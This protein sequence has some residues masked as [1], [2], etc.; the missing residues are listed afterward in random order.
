MEID[1]YECHCLSLY[2]LPNWGFTFVD[3][4]TGAA[5]VAP[6]RPICLLS[7]W[8]Y[9]VCGLPLSI[10]SVRV[11]CVLCSCGFPR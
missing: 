11:M 10:L 7:L 8:V 1:F 2:C 9:F 3:T 4:R 5:A 6:E